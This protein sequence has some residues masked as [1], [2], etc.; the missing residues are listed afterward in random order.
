MTPEEFDSAWEASEPVELVGK[1]RR[2][3]SV[4]AS[5]PWTMQVV[6]TGAA[7]PS[8]SL[9]VGSAEPIEANYAPAL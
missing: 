8:Q 6:P 1:V 5:V 7:A 9:H 4:G 2:A 3:Q